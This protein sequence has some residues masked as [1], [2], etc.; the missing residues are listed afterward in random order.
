MTG[1]VKPE[2]PSRTADR[3]AG[4]RRLSSGTVDLRHAVR[5]A[6][7]S[8]VALALAP[9][10]RRLALDPGAV[11]MYVVEELT[12]EFEGEPFER[13]V[14]SLTALCV[15]DRDVVGP[16]TSEIVI[17]QER[18]RALASWNAPCRYWHQRN[19]LA[20]AAEMLCIA[21]FASPSYSLC[22]E[23]RVSN[24]CSQII[25]VS[26]GPHFDSE[27]GVAEFAWERG[28][29]KIKAMHRQA[30]FLE[31]RYDWRMRN[32]FQY[33]R[34]SGP[35]T[36]ATGLVREQIYSVLGRMR[37][38]CFDVHLVGPRLPGS[39]TS[40]GRSDPKAPS[41]ATTSASPRAAR[42]STRASKER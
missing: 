28:A 33:L 27:K 34:E 24:A 22:D 4:G 20:P 16:V 29:W 37:R 14:F 10:Q 30:R 35:V 17:D 11:E 25:P 39:D 18:G 26:Y 36:A 3:Q 12:G 15:F 7:G 32:E 1:S 38:D 13:P 5:L 42:S 2:V 40:N 6:L 8:C 9:C 21:Y 23:E 41:R 31:R 19:V